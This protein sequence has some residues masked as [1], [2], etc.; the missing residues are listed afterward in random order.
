M[1]YKLVSLHIK[2]LLLK[3]QLMSKKINFEMYFRRFL[4][5]SPLSVA[6]WRAVEAGHLSKYVLKKPVLDL[7]CGFGEFMRG[8]TNDK[9]EVGVDI[10]A[11]DLFSAS[12]TNKYKN[13][14][15]ADARDLPF[16]D[17]TFNTIVS[18]STFEHIENPKEIFKECFRVLKPKGILIATIET[19]KVDKNSFYRPLLVKAG[20]KKLSNFLE[21]K[22][23]SFF[24][25][26]IIMEGKKWEKTAVDSGFKIQRADYII[27]PAV[28]KLYDFFII[29]SWPSQILKLFFGK[30]IVIRPKFIE[31]ILVKYLLK[32]LKDEKL[33]TNLL[34]VAKK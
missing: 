18:I 3:F 11:K 32:Y 2:P 30:R 33:G 21:K 26:H 25:R 8:F 4:K 29:T 28:V 22:Y 14:V 19:E 15:L 20:F 16:P 31:N 7:G 34:L 12:K 9:I 17:N 1:E 6:V 27:S 13:L 24:S 5:I 23:N 10:N